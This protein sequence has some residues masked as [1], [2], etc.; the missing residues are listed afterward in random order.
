MPTERDC[1]AA[2]AVADD[3]ALLRRLK[4]DRR[5]VNSEGLTADD[6]ARELHN[7]DSIEQMLEPRKSHQMQVVESLLRELE[8]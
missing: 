2:A 3:D 5:E 1:A 7:F 6:M 8:I 4:A